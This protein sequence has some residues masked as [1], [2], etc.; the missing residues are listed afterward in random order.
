MRASFFLGMYVVGVAMASDSHHMLD[1]T[2]LTTIFI[3]IALG[4]MDVIELIIRA[5]KPPTKP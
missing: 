5:Q 1:V 3:V 2:W 4:M